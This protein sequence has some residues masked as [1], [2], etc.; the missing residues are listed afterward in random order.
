MEMELPPSESVEKKAEALESLISGPLASSVSTLLSCSRGIPS[1]KDFHFYNNFDEFKLPAREI[2]S[3]AESSL[4]GIASSI[5]LWGSRKPPPPPNELDEAYEWL[6]NLND[7]LLEKFGVSMDD[8][9]SF[10]EKQERNGEAADSG[11]GFQLVCGKKKKRGVVQKQERDEGL[12]ASSGIKMVS[13]DKKA[14]AARAKVPF[15]LPNIPKP[16]TEFNILVNNKNTPFEHVWL[17]VS[18]D[19]SRFV[20]PLEKLS[21]LDF[22]DRDIIEDEITKPLSLESTPFKL[23]EGLRELK[24]LAAKLHEVDEFAVDLEHN[25]YRSFLGLTCLMQISTRTEDFIVDT[26]KLRVHIGPYLREVFKDPL[27]RKVMHGADRD[28]LWLQRDFGIYVCNLFDTGQGSRLLQLERNSLEYLLRHFCGVEANKEYQNADWRLRPLPDEMIKYAREDTHYLLHIYDLMRCRLLS[29]SSDENDLLLEVYKRSSEVCMQLYEKEILT[30]TS[31]RYIYGLSEADFD[32]KQLAIVA[33]LCEWRDKVAREEDESTGYILPNKAVLEIARQ[34]PQSSGNLR[35]LVKS[36]HQYVERHLN[37]VSSIIKNAIANSSAFESIAEEIRKERIEALAMHISKAENLDSVDQIASVGRFQEEKQIT[38]LSF[39]E[40]GHCDT[41]GTV[42]RELIENGTSSSSER[43]KDVTPTASV[44]VMK[45]P[46]RAFGALFGNSSRG[47]TKPLNGNDSEQEKNE[48]KVEQIKAS[49][50][51]PFFS[52][53]SEGNIPETSPTKKNFVATQTVPSPEQPSK[54]LTME[55]VI[56]LEN[57]TDGSDSPAESPKS[58]D[59]P[60]GDADATETCMSLSDLSSG[61][62]QCSQFIYERSNLQAN[63][64]PSVLMPF[65]YSTARKTMKF[66]EEIGGEDDGGGMIDGVR[67]ASR[68]AKEGFLSS[69]NNGERTERGNQPRRRQAFPPSGNRSTTYRC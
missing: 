59:R 26:L 38:E 8:F 4:G 53:A 40:T 44:Q 36:K 11:D 63:D 66:E 31:Y 64:R 43:T 12:S 14:T 3:K 58:V 67:P 39:L 6:V 56:P 34:M 48:N 18:E 16:Q 37:A 5:Y 2:A 32:S 29:L 17:E 47:K 19:N 49:V 68:V 1:G 21:V 25:Q 35:R 69:R 22:I 7:D 54:A 62:Q 65:D 24:E 30:D 45:K 33:G 57:G 55:E 20:H 46:A 23:V 52:F 9:R 27:K 60:N 10:R 42:K 50:I 15:H 61:F 13:R 28:I 51:L 41:V